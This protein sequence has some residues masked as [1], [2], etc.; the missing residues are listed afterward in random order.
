MVT[1]KLT[2]AQK[3]KATREAKKLASLKELGFE[4]KKVKRKRKPMSDAQKAAATERL[5]KAR[6][7]RG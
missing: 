3:A 2:S 7:A 5:A 4:R 1:K 6:E